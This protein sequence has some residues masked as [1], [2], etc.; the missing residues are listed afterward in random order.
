MLYRT[1]HGFC[2]WPISDPCK[3]CSYMEAKGG[4]WESCGTA[5]EAFSTIMQACIYI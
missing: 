2:E 1:E 4:T 5:R 3:M